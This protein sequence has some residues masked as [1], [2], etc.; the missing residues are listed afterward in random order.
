MSLTVYT[1]ARTGYLR[2]LW[3]RPRQPWEGNAADLPHRVRV[4]HVTHAR[5]VMANR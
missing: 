3:I 5:L 4:T 2:R 1:Y